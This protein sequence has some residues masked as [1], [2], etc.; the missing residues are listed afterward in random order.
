MA[1]KPIDSRASAVL[2]R[3]RRGP[4]RIGRVAGADSAR[5]RDALWP[6]P[7][8]L[9]D[10]GEA[11]QSRWQTRATDKVVVSVQGVSYF[12]KR[13][14]CPGWG[15]RLKNVFRK[16][17]GERSWEAAWLFQR[18]GIPT[19][20]P[21]VWMEERRWRL[22]GTSILAFPNLCASRS[23]LEYWPGARGEEQLRILRRAAV[24]IGNMHRAGV[25]H[26]D[27][28]WRNLLVQE[29]G[30]APEILLV[31]LDGYRQAGSLGVKDAEK[32]LAHFLRDLKRSGASEALGDHFR[33]TWR[34]NFLPE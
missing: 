29:E 31:D 6:D 26:G 16:S 9:F 8:R 2:L 23:L 17:R 30:G 28:N 1:R 19:P 22:L 13:Y 7:G 3:E 24:V 15:Y 5:L 14:N 21:L 18:L 34:Q 32:D 33:Q 25:L 20:L 27:L 10:Q 12:L 4:Y 11:I